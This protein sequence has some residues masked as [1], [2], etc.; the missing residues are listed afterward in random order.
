M[1]Q[2]IQQFDYSVDLLR[3][4]LWQ[5][6]QAERLQK[7]VTEKQA[8]Y[9]NQQSQFW[10]DWFTDVFDLRTANDFGLSVWSIILGQPLFVN[11]SAGDIPSWGF[12][13]FHRNFTRG[14]FSS[15]SSSHNQ[16]R[17][18]TES[19]RI[20]LQLR[21]F[22]LTSAGTVPE[23]NRMLAYVFKDY[24]KSWLND[25]HDMTQFYTFTFPLT[26]ELK[27]LFGH[28]DILPRP[29]GVGS[30]YRIVVR[31]TWAFDAEREN[32]DNGNFSSE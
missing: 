3:A 11:L 13:T 29:A 18:S 1:T 21:Y 8:W 26:A 15:A 31:P 17:L 24:G 23:I 5:Y 25:N 30:F 6:N 14:N 22:Q 28:F 7:L 12:G 32:F 2:T 27:F 9:D 16:Q 4:L 10:S 20:L 19:S